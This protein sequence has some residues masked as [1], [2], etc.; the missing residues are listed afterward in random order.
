MSKQIWLKATLELDAPTY[1]ELMQ[2]AKQ[3]GA[4]LKL[5][6]HSPAGRISVP[7][8]LQGMWVQQELF[9]DPQP[10]HQ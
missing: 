9:T 8:Q 6:L 3:K 4:Y 1:R 10:E 7:L 2:R 5:E